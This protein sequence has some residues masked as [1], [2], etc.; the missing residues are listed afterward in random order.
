MSTKTMTAARIRTAVL[1]WVPT[2][3]KFLPFPCWHEG[4]N[5]HNYLLSAGSA[6]QKNP[7]CLCWQHHRGSG[8][9]QPGA[10]GDAFAQALGYLG[11]RNN[12]ERLP[13]SVAI[14]TR[15][16]GTTPIYPAPNPGAANLQVRI[17]PMGDADKARSCKKAA[18]LAMV[19]RKCVLL[20]V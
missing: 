13:T 15:I 6:R 7:Y 17:R 14:Q 9:G 20:A 2:W 11:T 18:V 4:W 5:F 3:R 19:R 8:H 12:L 10:G 16:W 1:P